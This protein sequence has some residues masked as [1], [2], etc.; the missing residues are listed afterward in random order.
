MVTVFADTFTQEELKDRIA[1]YIDPGRVPKSIRVITDTSD[2]FR[3][4]YDDV[5]ILNKTTYLARNY[6]REGRFSIDEQPKFWVRRAIDLTDGSMKIIKMV[7]LE[8]F[9]SRIGEL[10][11]INL[12][13][14]D[15]FIIL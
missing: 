9:Q 7:F 1:H 3:V 10:T 2:F 11:F 5:I 13:S 8:K 6:E 4:D 14:S 12:T 15:S